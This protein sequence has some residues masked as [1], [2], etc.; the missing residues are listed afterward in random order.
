METLTTAFLIIFSL[1]LSVFLVYKGI[2][3]VRKILKAN[4]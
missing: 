4:K 1:S 2:T 3:G